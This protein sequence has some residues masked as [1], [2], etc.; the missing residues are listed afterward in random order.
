MSSGEQLSTT[1]KIAAVQMVSTPEPA[2]NR[3]TVERR[4]HEA[5]DAGASLVLLP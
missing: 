2:E 1:L 3:R 4:I 5:A